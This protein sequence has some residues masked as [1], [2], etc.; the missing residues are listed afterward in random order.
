[1]IYQGYLLIVLILPIVGSILGFI[2]GR[3]NERRR[4]VLNIIITGL[5]LVMVTFLYGAVVSGNIEL[6]IPD[7]MGIGLYLKLDMFRY[8]FIWITSLIWF[9]TTL[10]STQYLIRYKNRNRYYAFF[11]MTLSSTLGI[12]MSEN[13]LNLFT[14]FEI[15]SF[16]S[17]ILVIHDE[18][19]Y[20]HD[21]GKSYIAMAIG[22][23]LVLLMGLFLLYDYTGTLNISELK[24]VIGEIGN[25]KYMISGLIIIGFGVKAGMVPLHTWLP[26]AHPAAPAPASA[27]LSGILIKT[28][29]FGIMIVV[30]IIMDGDIILSSVILVLGFIN[31]FVGG[32]LAILQRNIKRILA[33]SSMSQIGY[34][35]MGIGL[36]GILKEHKAIAIYGVLYHVINHAFFKVLLFLG[37][38]IIYMILHEL[39]INLIKGF[40]RGKAGLKVLFLIGSLAVAGVPGFNGYIS[41]ILLH[42]AL[43]EAHHMYPTIWFTIAEVI[44]TISS[45]FTVAYLLKLFITVFVEKNEEYNGQYKSHIRKRALIP[46]T[47]L[48]FIIIYIGIK[49]YGILGMLDGAVNIFGVEGHL[50]TSFYS[51]ANIKSSLTTILLGTLIYFVV[52]RSFL[53]KEVKGEKIYVNPSLRWPGLEENLYNPLVTLFFKSSSHIFH[54]I[55]KGAINF[56][57][58]STESIKRLSGME[59]KKR[60]YEGIKT[61]QSIKI[62]IKPKEIAD[63]ISKDVIDTLHDTSSEISNLKD[64]IY[65]IRGNMNSMIYSVFTFAIV[66]I[67]VLVILI[68]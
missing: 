17:Y 28:G 5:E 65:K 9:L 62:D 24:H 21:A 26:K 14:F 60:K 39:S 41:K 1:V 23:G 31:M 52:V 45:S 36:A 19:E 2:I 48:S 57:K 38:G 56:V 51:L 8:I 50:E 42:E 47:V 37:A 55:D 59:I 35:L 30:C 44:F 34:I 68:I 4:D 29:V 63:K 49:P 66:L 16:T 7:I 32:I 40:G 54:L 15:M 64:I 22:G 27:V 25:I 58:Y 61:I 12:F 18:D 43:A 10:Y 13:L 20:A 33:Y 67:I 6:F 53:R 11:M 46:M 3:K